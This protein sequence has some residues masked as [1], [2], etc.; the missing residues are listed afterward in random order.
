MQRIL[1]ID[2][3]PAVTSLLKRGLSY[4]GYAV[5]IAGSGRDGLCRI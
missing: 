2:D 1:T 4:E 5:D 3:D